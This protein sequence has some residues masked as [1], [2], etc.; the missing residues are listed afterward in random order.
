MNI[1]GLDYRLHHPFHDPDHLKE[2]HA[3]V[4]VLLQRERPNPE[5]FRGIIPDEEI[6][7]D[8]RTVAE[9]EARWS[10]RDTPLSIEVKMKAD[11]AEYMIYKNLAGWMNRLVVPLIMSKADDYLRGIDLA[12]ES[13]SMDLQQV[14]HLGIGI[15]VALTSE[16]K[17]S[18]QVEEKI[19][20][21]R[22]I[23][24]TGKMNEAR[25]VS[26]GSY[27]G[28]IKNLPYIILSISPSY[29]EELFSQVLTKGQT[30]K[31]MNHPLKYAVAYQI[32]LQ[33]NTYALVAEKKGHRTLAHSL[34]EA[35]NLAVDLFGHLI[36]ELHA[37]P[38]LWN[39][40][41]HDQGTKEIIEFCNSLEQ[42]YAHG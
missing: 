21:V 31:E 23:L 42:E 2:V 32:V 4:E 40:I 1:A 24:K 25:Y 22:G 20:K 41:S 11:I 8:L 15:D 26:G 37:D 18:T 19:H 17:L 35:N 16:K 39:K 9:L 13:E 28:R 33:L 34:A 29:V 27:E 7:A 10:R 6:D 30:E 38:V 14:K 12:I 5:D 3:K 36:E